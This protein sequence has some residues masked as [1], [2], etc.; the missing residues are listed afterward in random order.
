[1]DNAFA[2]IIPSKG[3]GLSFKS[4][5][6]L[7]LNAENY[8]ILHRHLE[9]I[10]SCSGCICWAL[11]FLLNVMTPNLP[12][13]Q[14]SVKQ[15]IEGKMIIQRLLPLKPSSLSLKWNFGRHLYRELVWTSLYLRSSLL[16][17]LD[18]VFWKK[19]MFVLRLCLN[20]LTLLWD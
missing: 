7:K 13:C 20:S 3:N 6:F 10:L 17:F 8:R 12:N 14:K 9:F 16:A 1:M 18:L 5:N 11:A 19:K 4:D 2:K 15:R